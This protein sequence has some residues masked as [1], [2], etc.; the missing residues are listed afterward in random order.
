[1][2]ARRLQF[3]VV[4]GNIFVREEVRDGRI[5]IS[6]NGDDSPDS[7]VIAELVPQLHQLL[8]L[9]AQEGQQ[10]SPHTDACQH[11]LGLLLARV[12]SYQAAAAVT[13]DYVHL[14][15]HYVGCHSCS[16]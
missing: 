14:L 2:I 13:H 12:L 1:M 7:D 11:F 6:E 9:R 10:G 4:Q 15:I 5:A 16:F 8:L 3:E